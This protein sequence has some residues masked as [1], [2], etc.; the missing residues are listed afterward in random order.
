MQTFHK[1]KNRLFVMVSGLCLLG[2]AV[3]VAQR[4][5]APQTPTARDA[6]ELSQVFRSVSQKTTPGVVSI[7]MHG[8]PVQMRGNM[9]FGG[10]GPFQ[11]LFRDDPRFQELFKKQQEKKV[12]PEGRGSG[13]VIDQSGIIVTNNHVVQDAERITV[14]LYDEREFEAELIGADPR[15]DIAILKIDAPK[16]L[17]ALNLGDSDQM[18]VG[19][20]VLAVGSPFGYELSVT[21]GI[22]SGKGRGPRINEREDYLQ[23]DAAINPGNSG[24]PLLNLDGEVIGINTAISSRSGGYDGI[25]FA[26]PVNMAKWVLD[27]LRDQGKVTRAY[28]GVKMK[29]LDTALSK[30]LG[31]P[32]G[33]G[34]IVSE[35][36]PKSPAAQGKIQTGDVIMKLKGKSVTS[37]RHLQELVEKLEIGKS[38]AMTVLR[39]GEKVTLNVPGTEIPENFSL[40]NRKKPGRNGTPQKPKKETFENL[41]LDIQELTPELTRQLGLK[42]A[43]GEPVQGVLVENVKVNS[44]AHLAG[45]RSG[46]VIQKVES[47]RTTSPE[48]FR[49]AIKKASLEKGILIHIRNRGGS[50]VLVIQAN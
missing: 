32:I 41:G 36:F 6:R 31:V 24:G 33:E 11:E 42:D 15:S 44:P 43:K 22:I 50:D 38:H 27:Q 46:D 21:A 35:V 49:E 20:W 26:V 34:V 12:V 4:Q 9:P 16:N 8:K 14:S 28:L 5:P 17:T 25:G 10:N 29:P 47:T 37:T 23:T 45:I 13:F 30:R 48:V 39:D 1:H 40:L 19:D 3:V 18:Q 7:T 2:A